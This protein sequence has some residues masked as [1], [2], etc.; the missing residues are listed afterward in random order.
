M[1]VRMAWDGPLSSVRLIMQ[2]RNVKLSD[3]VKEHIEDKVGRAVAKHCHLVARWTCVCRPAAA[4]C[5]GGPKTSRCEITLFTT[6]T[7]CSAPRRI[8]VTYGSIDMAASIIKRKLRKIKEKETE[9]IS[10][11]RAAALKTTC[12]CFPMPRRRTW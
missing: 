7:A 3:K 8:G 5:G 10:T 11:R 4:S 12:S 6:A 1:S 9:V 2:R